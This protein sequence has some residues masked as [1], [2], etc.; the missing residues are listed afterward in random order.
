M[1]NYKTH[2]PHPITQ[3]TG[4][5]LI[6]LGTPEEATPQAVRRYLAEFLSDPKVVEINPVLWKIILHGFI[7]RFRPAKVALKYQRIWL[8][9]G[10]PLLV[11][12]EQ[13]KNALQASLQATR[14]DLVI[15]LGMRYGEPSIE[16]ALNKLQQAQIKK[17]IVLPLY[18]QYSSTTTGTAFQEVMRVIA[19]WR[20]NPECHFINHYADDLSYIHAIAASIKAYWALRGRHE[21]LLFSFHGLPQKNLRLGDPYYCYCHKTSRLIASFLGLEKSEWEMVFQ[22][23]FGQEAWLQPYCDQSLIALAK[24]GVKHVDIVCPGF[25]VDCLETLEEISIENAALFKTHGGK[26]LNYIPALNHSDNHVKL[27]NSLLERYW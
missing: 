1:T 8:A 18:P 9:E 4:V 14:N 21:K 24:E 12:S 26:T 23:R 3:K 22:S 7:L 11:Y 19:S 13:L 16:T 27:L 6:N 5:L 2:P 17:L 25:A 15:E 20:F 10:S